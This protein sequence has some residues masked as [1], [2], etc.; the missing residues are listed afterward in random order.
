M[1]DACTHWPKGVKNKNHR[2]ARSLIWIWPNLDIWRSESLPKLAT[3]FLRPI[4]SNKNRE[5]D[6]LFRVWEMSNNWVSI[7]FFTRIV[8][9]TC[10]RCL[11]RSTSSYGLVVRAVACE[12]RRLGFNP[13]S[14]KFF[15]S[16][17]IKVA[18]KK[19]EPAYMMSAHRNKLKRCCLVQS[20]TCCN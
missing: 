10:H 5:L 13:R 18:R 1:V 9:G 4:Q 20:Q 19:W 8:Q 15:L 14:F 3:S 6:D 17:G 7:N 2:L 12:A 11:S 16:M